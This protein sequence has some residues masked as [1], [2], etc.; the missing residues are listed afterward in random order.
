MD[1]WLVVM[2]SVLREVFSVTERRIVMMG[3]MKILV[4]SF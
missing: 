2:A 1:T 3:P 4:V